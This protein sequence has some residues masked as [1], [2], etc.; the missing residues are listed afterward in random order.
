MP[1]VKRWKPVRFIIIAVM[2]LC[3]CGRRQQ[4]DAGEK[5]TIYYVNHDETGVVPY[6]YTSNTEDRDLLIEEL[7]EQLG[8]VSEKLE[9]RA[10]LSGSVNLLGY[11]ISEDQLILNFSESYRQQSVINEVLVRASIVRTM[12]QIQGI[13]YVS[14]Q[15]NSEPFADGSGTVV[16]VMSADQFID[17]EGNEINTYERVKLTLYLANED[18]DRLS[19]VT[20]SVVYNSNISME[21]LVLEQL[22]AG[23]GENEKVFPTVNPETKILSVNVK[24]GTC[25]VNLDSTFLTQIYNVTSD[26]T[27]YSIANS[28]VE[29]SNVNKVQIAINGDTNVSYK[30]NISFSTV[31][32]RNLEL[33][34]Q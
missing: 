1:I 31:F 29:L 22:I 27:I 20:R 3:A 21:R 30:E 8:K 6:D 13:Q 12:T 18:G 23:P 17:N 24:D 32:E 2:L 15:V 26:V 25:Y 33:V 14:F 28:L 34:E 5:Y 19:P 7:L 11:T 9:Y 4:A 16:G 10:P